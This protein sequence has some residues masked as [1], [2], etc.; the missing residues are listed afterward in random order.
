MRT[1]IISLL[2][3]CTTATCWAADLTP[4]V[5]SDWLE[6]NQAEVKIIDIRKAD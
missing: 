5:S 3:L 6:K 2:L 4:L 1:L